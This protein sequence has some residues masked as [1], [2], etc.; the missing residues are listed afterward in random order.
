MSE[1]SRET[2][3]NI[4]ETDHVQ[5]GDAS[6]L[7]RMALAA[8]DSEPHTD[9]ELSNLLWYSQ[10]ATCHSDPNYYCE[11][12]RLATPGLIAGI[13]RE[14]QERRKA[15]SEPV[16]IVGD[17]GGDALSYRRLIQSF[18]PGTKLYRH[19]QPV[20]ASPVCTCPSGDGSLRWPCLV[21]P[22]NSPAQS[23]CCPAQNHV[24]PEQNGDTPAQSQGWIQIS[25]QM[26]P[27]RHEVLVGSWW[28]EKPRW[29]CKWATYI[30]GHPDAQSSGWLIPGAS[31]TPTHW[32]P[33]PAAPQPQNSPQ[34]IPEIIPGWIPVSEQKPDCWC[35]T[36]RPVTLNDMRFVVCPDCGNKRCPRA[37]D[38]RNACTGSNEPG[39][40]GS[41]YPAAPQEVKGE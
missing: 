16:I 23:D 5:C 28:G 29:C 31:W 14:L 1:F 36:C 19:A 35:L 37:N 9:D 32:M 11:F 40:E 2:L 39:Q 4:I 6:A 33:L 3:L 25:E 13:I 17:D 41:A 24:S 27:S 10:E 8:M 7:A 34:N 21:H 30:P 26:P 18:E 38:H 15:D 12:Q 22:G 20:P